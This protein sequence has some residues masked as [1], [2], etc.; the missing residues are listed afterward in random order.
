MKF[1]KDNGNFPS[2]LIG[3]CRAMPLGE[4]PILLLGTKCFALTPTRYPRL[5]DQLVI[6]VYQVG[7]NE[8]HTDSLCLQP[9]EGRGITLRHS[10][11]FLCVPGVYSRRTYTIQL[12]SL[13]A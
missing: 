3:K 7:F 5:E 2:Q 9:R 1:T 13:P 10:A 4:E 6:F 8:A 12:F 11:L